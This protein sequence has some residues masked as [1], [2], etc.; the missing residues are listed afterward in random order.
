MTDSPA[1]PARTQG[2]AVPQRI[3]LH[4]SRSLC[5][6]DAGRRRH[7]RLGRLRAGRRLHCRPSMDVVRPPGRAA[8]SRVRRFPRPPDRDGHRP[9]RAAARRG[10]LRRR[11]ARRRRA[12]RRGADSGTGGTVLGHGWDETLWADPALPGRE[13]LERAAGGRKVYLSRVDVHSAL[14]SSSLASRGRARRPR[15]FRRRQP[16][17]TG[18]P[19]RRPACGT[20]APRRR[21]PRATSSGP[22]PRQPPTAT[23]PS[24][25]WR[26]RTSAASR[27]C[28]SRR[29][30]T[31]ARTVHR[32]FRK[33]LPYWGQLAASADEARSILDGLGV[34]VLGLA[35]DLNIDGSIGSRTA[36]LRADYSDAPGERGSLYLSVAE[37]GGPSGRVLAAGHPGGLPRDRGRR[38]GRGPGR[39]GRGRRR[40]GGTAGPRRR[41]PL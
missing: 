10:P 30:G 39:P 31:P 13:E 5:H 25:R 14:V 35:G 17:Q 8:G 18:R 11:T 28:S 20:A 40:G 12:R 27:T 9:G 3:G 15:R 32:T 19:H 29:P 6:G 1:A 7:G 34:S 23:W 37:A 2:H 38:P 22:W 36:A 21:P 33:I 24:P 16:G 4:R 26:P 41:P